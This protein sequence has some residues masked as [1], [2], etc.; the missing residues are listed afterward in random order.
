MINI[1]LIEDDEEINFILTEFLKRQHYSVSTFTNGM[2]AIQALSSHTFDLLLLDL[3]LPDLSGESILQHIKNKKSAM[4][5][6]IISAQTQPEKKI[7][8]LRSG[9][10]DYITKPFYYEEVLARIQ[11]VL[12]RCNSPDLICTY[13]DIELDLDMHQISVNKQVITLTSTEFK[14]LEL[15]IKHP[16][17][18]YTKEALYENIWNKDY[19]LDDNTLN[20]HISNLRKKIEVYGTSPPYI[21]TIRSIGYRLSP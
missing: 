10:D 2:D 1:I 14:I 19:Y 12:R 20:V 17:Q 13:K 5:I 7:D 8:L 16:K 11:S 3:S 9:A 18:I 4:P 21:E 6:I 15:F